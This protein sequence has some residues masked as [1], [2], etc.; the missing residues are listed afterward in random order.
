MSE[1]VVRG[2]LCTFPRV[3]YGSPYLMHN[4]SRRD[5]RQFCDK[6]WVRNDKSPAVGGKFQTRRQPFCVNNKKTR[7]LCLN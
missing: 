6:S 4:T 2:G 5:E 1:E 3:G 7:N